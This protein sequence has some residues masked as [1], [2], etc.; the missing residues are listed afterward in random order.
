VVIYGDPAVIAMEVFIRGLGVSCGCEAKQFVPE[1]RMNVHKHARM[2]SHGR[3]LTWCADEHF[4]LPIAAGIWLLSRAGSVGQRRE[5][6]HLMTSVAVA[7]VLPHLSDCAGPPGPPGDPG[8]KAWHSSLRQTLRRLSFGARDAC[9]SHR[10]GDRRRV[11]PCSALRL[12]NRRASGRQLLAHWTTD[13]LAGLAMGIGVERMLRSLSF[14]P[15]DSRRARTSRVR[16]QR[17]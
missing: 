7:A 12:D 13:V 3:L 16:R 9:R 15:T 1:P 4:V 11:S 10:V 5:A 2:T 6:D 14:K 8:S 17:F